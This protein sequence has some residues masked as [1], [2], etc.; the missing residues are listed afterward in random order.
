MNAQQ[1]SCADHKITFFNIE[2]VEVGGNAKQYPGK[3]YFT[4]TDGELLWTNWR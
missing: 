2:A 4:N 1:E 3:H